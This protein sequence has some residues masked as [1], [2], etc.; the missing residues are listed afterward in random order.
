MTELRRMLKARELKTY[1]NPVARWMADNLEAKH[2]TDD[3]DRV[4]PVK[5]GRKTSGKR[6]DGMPAQG[7]AIDGSLAVDDGAVAD[8]FCPR[9]R[10]AYRWRDHH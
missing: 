7:S 2:P 10:S 1:G 9:A 5:P 4:R 3:P 8:I 6:I